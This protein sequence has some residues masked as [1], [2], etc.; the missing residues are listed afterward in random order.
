MPMQQSLA[1]S[2]CLKQ[3]KSSTFPKTQA[4]SKAHFK[5]NFCHEK[6]EK[7]ILVK[8]KYSCNWKCCS[9]LSYC[10]TPIVEKNLKSILDIH[11]DKTYFLPPA[12]Q[13]R[14]WLSFLFFLDFVRSINQRWTNLSIESGQFAEQKTKLVILQFRTVTYA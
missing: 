8:K 6:T 2:P 1:R 3:Y 4:V 14:S 13:F 7:D 12:K 10:N 11:P 5:W 9:Y